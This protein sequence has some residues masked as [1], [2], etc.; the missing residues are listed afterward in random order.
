M[1]TMK[2][3]MKS[4]LLVLMMPRLALSTMRGRI[5]L[6]RST[7]RYVTN[8]IPCTGYNN[9]VASQKLLPMLVHPLRA[10]S[11]PLLLLAN[12]HHLSCSKKV[13]TLALCPPQG[14]LQLQLLILRPLPLPLVQ[15]LHHREHRENVLV[16]RHLLMKA[17]LRLK[18]LLP[19]QVRNMR[20]R[21]WSMHNGWLI[22][23]SR[24]NT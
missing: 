1:T 18:V 23:I 16:G 9:Y 2:M 13:G 11:T 19:L 3:K 21:W 17:K 24:S 4:K 10:K 15:P 12:L 20:G 14:H 8:S 22:W 7:S 5:V 6:C